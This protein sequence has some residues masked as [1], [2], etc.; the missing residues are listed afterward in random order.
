MGAPAGVVIYAIAILGLGV[1]LPVY[2]S[3]EFL[4][5]AVLVSYAC[6]SLLLVPPVIA[7]SF[8]GDDRWKE[9]VANSGDRRWLFFDKVAAGVLYG[10]I[11]SVI[12]VILGLATV[13]A[14]S[15]HLVMP[16]SLVAV[17]LLLLSLTVSVFASSAA[18]AVSVTARSAKQAK[19]TL[20]QA[21]LLLLVI[22]IYYL[23]MT[24]GAW[25]ERFAIPADISG[26]TKFVLVV[27]VL[28]VGLSGGLLKLAWNRSEDTEIRL[29][30]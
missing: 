5:R 2:L 14:S 20:R 23:R 9:T 26:F 1:V 15:G 7:E 3:F 4:D 28:L 25:K 8:A 17:D 13:A 24:P 22:L 29:K 12:A 21:L 18:A 10:W 19:R 30:I 6:L 11:S 16:P 27:S